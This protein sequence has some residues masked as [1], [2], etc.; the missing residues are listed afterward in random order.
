MKEGKEGE[1]EEG[2]KKDSSV[3]AQSS[4]FDLEIQAVEEILGLNYCSCC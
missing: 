1:W 4:S 3:R 2:E